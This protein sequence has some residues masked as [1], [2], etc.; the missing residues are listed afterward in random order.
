MNKK[1]KYIFSILALASFTIFTQGCGDENNKSK[2]EIKLGLVGEHSDEWNHV[3]KKLEKE[4]IKL[5][6]I[7]FADY[8]LP[9]R[10]LNDGE[11]DANAFQHKAF[12]KAESEANGYKL[13]V[14]A[15][16]IIAPLGAYSTKIKSLEE[17]KDGDKIAIPN[18]PT[19]G[20]R[21]IR[22]LESAGLIT[23]DKAKGYLVTVRD[24]QNNPKHLEIIEV[25]A[26]NTPSLLPDVAV[27]VINS[28]YAIDNG[29]IPVKDAIYL[30]ATGKI[31][32]NNPYINVLV[33]REDNKNSEL[34]KKLVKVYQ[35]KDTAEIINKA[36]K[37]ASI[38]AFKY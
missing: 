13:T 33:S 3:A 26:G 35:T 30:D 37:G 27:S 23:A 24:I 18:D 7:K 31:D 25:D 1:L 32:E 19:N 17:L 16:T 20:G 8:N 10:A 6:L 9:N 12:L 21:A 28:N 11:I 29:L 5:T 14:I 38:P 34:L 4:G 36:Y 15:D 2:S 22:L